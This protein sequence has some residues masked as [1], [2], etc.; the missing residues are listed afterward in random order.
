MERLIK[1]QLVQVP[2]I[3]R[4]ARSDLRSV[5]AQKFTI[6]NSTGIYLS[7]CQKFT[8]GNSPCPKLGEIFLMI[9]SSE[10]KLINLSPFVYIVDFWRIVVLG[11]KVRRIGNHASIVVDWRRSVLLPKIQLH[12]MTAQQSNSDR[13][14]Q[15]SL[16]ILPRQYWP[17]IKTCRKAD[18]NVSLNLTW[19]WTNS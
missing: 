5:L 1:Q 17:M 13:A 12:R 15:N 16:K 18:W 2:D 7:L 9:L 10:D 14:D 8:T 3:P 19:N 11:R 4:G 6:G